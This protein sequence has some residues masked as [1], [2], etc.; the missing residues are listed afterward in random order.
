VR[1]RDFFGILGGATAW[2]FAAN[3]QP[4]LTARIGFLGNVQVPALWQA[5]IEGLREH[6]WEEGHNLVIESRWVQGRTER[7]PELA[8]E[9]VSL[10]PDLIVASSPPAVQA[11]QHATRTIPIVMTLV[12]F[13][14]E[15][16]L[17]ASLSRPGGNVTGLASVAGA[18]FISKMLQLTKEALPAA[19]RV[20]VL[21]NRANPLNYAMVQ[22][23]ELRAAAEA[24]GVELVWLPAERKGDFESAFAE[25][26]RRR[27]DAVI[28]IGDPLLF[29][30]RNHI[31]DL[32]DEHRLPTIWATREY[33][34][35]RGLLSHGPSL[36]EML[37]GVAPHVNKLL[38]GAD[39]A[40]LPVELPTRYELVV[41]LRTAR[42]LGLTIPDA[43]LA[44][45]DEVIE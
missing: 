19:A 39:P 41:N 24:L 30:E 13:P 34:A 20:G 3:S 11:T 21:F 22:S 45:A 17:V 44:R 36:S 16:G 37:R 2:P 29:A 42:A 1:R 25:A 32:A 26:H 15:A 28:G 31:H 27:V 40:T 5:F 43:V 10:K 18:G 23:A 8:T 14:V 33:L 7:Y 35:S 4:K 6:G 38:R 12:A 9:L